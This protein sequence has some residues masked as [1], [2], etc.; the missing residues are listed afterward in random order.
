MRTLTVFMFSRA[1]TY[2]KGGVVLC[3]HLGVSLIGYYFFIYLAWPYS[4]NILLIKGLV[5]SSGV[6][7]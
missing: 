7:W 3:E 2:P 5:G 1:K 6:C 4:G